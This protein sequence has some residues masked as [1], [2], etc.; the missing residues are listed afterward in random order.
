VPNAAVP[1]RCAAVGSARSSRA[2]N[3]RVRYTSRQARPGPWIVPTD[4]LQ[5]CKAAL[6][7]RDRRLMVILAAPATRS[8]STRGDSAQASRVPAAATASWRAAAH[9]EGAGILRVLPLSQ[10]DSQPGIARDGETCPECG[11]LGGKAHDPGPGRLRRCLKGQAPSFV[12][13][14]EAGAAARRDPHKRQRR[15]G[16]GGG[17]R[18]KK[19]RPGRWTER[20]FSV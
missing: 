11:Y 9:E 20:G 10:G 2:P 19:G 12:G 7:S 4:R 18:K 13:G 3:T 8:A 17:V 1:S 6:A 5:G 15:R 16:A 14:G